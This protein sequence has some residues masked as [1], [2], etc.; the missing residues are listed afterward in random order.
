MDMVLPSVIFQYWRHVI[1]LNPRWHLAISTQSFT[2]ELFE[3]IGLLIMIK[4]E[5][6]K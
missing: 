3:D 2:M 4:Y 5:I 6:Y 1:F